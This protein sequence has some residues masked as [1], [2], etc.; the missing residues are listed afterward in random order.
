MIRDVHVI[1]V[2]TIPTSLSYMVVLN[3]YNHRKVGIFG[4]RNHWKVSP[5]KCESSHNISTLIFRKDLLDRIL[6]AIVSF[7]VGFA[8]SLKNMI[9][10]D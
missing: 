3:H 1:T 5:K 7:Y 10:G 6:L 8:Y 2:V 9:V 4:L